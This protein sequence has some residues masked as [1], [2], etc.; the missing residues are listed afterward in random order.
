MSETAFSR[1][2]SGLSAL[3]V[4]RWGEKSIILLALVKY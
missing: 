2:P 4:E 3:K 1:H